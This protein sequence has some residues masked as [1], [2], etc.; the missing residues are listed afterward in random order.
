M[1]PLTEQ[2]SRFESLRKEII[3]GILEAIN[4]HKRDYFFYAKNPEYKMFAADQ[5][6]IIDDDNTTLKFFAT[7]KPRDN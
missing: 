7:L 5:Q 1:N 6:N 2:I 4:I 3:S